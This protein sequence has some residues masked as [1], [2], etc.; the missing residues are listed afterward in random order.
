[1]FLYLDV[2]HI[3]P[4]N[5]LA[6]WKGLA[7]SNSSAPQHSGEYVEQAHLIEIPLFK[8]PFS[9]SAIVVIKTSKLRYKFTMLFAYMSS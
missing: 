2:T 8:R 6:V 3:S 5:V 9:S 7:P 1:M 4:R